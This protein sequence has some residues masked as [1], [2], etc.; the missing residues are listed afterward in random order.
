ME[1]VWINGYN[2]MWRFDTCLARLTIFHIIRALQWTMW[3][4]EEPIGTN[5]AAIYLY[6]Y[7]VKV[8]R[9]TA[10]ITNQPS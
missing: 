7:V 3:G 8:L 1:G 4:G 5:T 6:T 2:V 10:P 9:L